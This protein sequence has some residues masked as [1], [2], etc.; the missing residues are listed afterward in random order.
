MSTL[1]TKSAT[2]LGFAFTAA[3]AILLQLLYPSAAYGQTKGLQHFDGAWWASANSDERVGFLYALDDCLT[4][5]EKPAMWFDDTWANYEKKISA[6]Y[7]SS[8]ADR[9]ASVEKVFERFGKTGAANRTMQQGERY[10]DEF[11]R[12]HSEI[13]RRGFLEGYFSCRIRDK[14]AP[15]WSKPL[16]FY[17]EKLND[18]YNADDRNGENAPEYTG[19]VASALEKLKDHQ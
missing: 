16:D 3:L 6:Y 1:D 4:Y 7:A 11:W 15:K 18:L 12:A 17:R 19:S 13:A 8:S 5:D 9:S 14:N 10:G 2:I